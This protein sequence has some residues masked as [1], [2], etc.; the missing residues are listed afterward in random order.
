MANLADVREALAVWFNLPPFMVDHLMTRIT[1]TV[2]LD[3]LV[4]LAAE[5]GGVA[6]PRAAVHSASIGPGAGVKSRAQLMNPANSGIDIEVI[7]TSL[8]LATAGTVSI[9]FVNTAVAGA[10][11]N[12]FL[13]QRI[14]ITPEFNVVHPVGS[15]TYDTNAASGI[16][17]A[18]L[19]YAQTYPTTSI[20]LELPRPVVLPPGFG[21]RIVAETVNVQLRAT[22]WTL[23]TPRRLA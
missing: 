15:F 8:S 22:I 7:A 19:L 20:T 17:A 23:E 1:P 5:R 13:D 9:G 11:V 3:T 6:G 21:L 18:D 14:G 4:E 12:R 10:G 2:D 16:A